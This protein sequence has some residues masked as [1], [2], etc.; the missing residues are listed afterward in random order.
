MSKILGSRK[1]FAVLAVLFA[2]AAFVQNT[3]AEAQTAPNVLNPVETRLISSGPTMP[4][5]PWDDVT[6]MA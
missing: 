5:G 6:R 2:A 4:P 1:V 3:Q